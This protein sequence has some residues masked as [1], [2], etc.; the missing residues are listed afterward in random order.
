MSA[1]DEVFDDL[2]AASR[3]LAAQDVCDA[4]GHISARNPDNPD[5]YFLSCARAPQLVERDDIMEFSFDGT[6]VGG[7]TRKPFLERFIHGS[8]YEARPD[9]HSVVHSHS[10]SVLPFTVT[11]AR[12]RPLVHSCATIGREVPV[13]D[14]QTRFGDTNLL[15]ANAEMG[16]D[17][18]TV[19]ADGR[20]ALMRGHGSTVVGGSIREAVYTAV[21]LEVNA[22]L[23][24][25]ASALGPITFLTDGEIETIQ[26]RLSD[27]KP[28]EGYDRAW[29][30]WC[31][32]AGIEPRGA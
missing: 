6:P 27:A 17:F 15:I 11:P 23:Q 8:L 13:W 28:G 21:Y 29:Q 16:R 31:R 4:F 7:D 2:V 30:Y 1:H 22:S 20:S 9:V 24:I 18:A 3:I 26:S 14:A 5:T 10:R 25:Q 12:L 19:M 32:Q